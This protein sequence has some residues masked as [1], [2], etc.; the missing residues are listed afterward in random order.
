MTSNLFLNQKNL[1][2]QTNVVPRRSPNYSVLHV[3]QLNLV[4]LCDVCVL[5]DS[6][7]YNGGIAPIVPAVPFCGCLLDMIS[8]PQLSRILLG[9]ALLLRSC[10]SWTVFGVLI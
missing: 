4:E 9:T 5:D 8:N 3:L 6:V 2:N 1:L 7:G 10:P